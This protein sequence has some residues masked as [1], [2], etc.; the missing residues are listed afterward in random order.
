M[1]VISM[2][3]NHTGAVLHEENINELRQVKE[4]GGDAIPTSAFYADGND[5]KVLR[6]CFA[7]KESTLV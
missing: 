6:F 2:P 1:I 7:K 3:R 5:Y 4:F